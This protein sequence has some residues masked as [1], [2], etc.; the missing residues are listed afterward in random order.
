MAEWRGPE[1]SAVHKG[2]PNN[3]IDFAD[4]QRR[5]KQAIQRVLS[6]KGTV[7]AAD[8]LYKV[9]EKLLECAVDKESPHYQFAVKEIGLRLDGKPTERVQITDPSATAAVIGIS[10]AFAKLVEL[11]SG[12]KVINGEV[13]M[14]DGSLL[15][16]PVR[17]TENGHGEGLDISE[18]PGSTSES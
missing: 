17:V 16:A 13:V 15:P 14:P 2:L 11:Q 18:V 8:E 1:G 3:T 12:G 5:W 6:K 7:N 10:A 9:A 4:P